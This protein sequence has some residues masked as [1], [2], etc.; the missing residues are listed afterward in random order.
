MEYYIGG[1]VS[2]G[3][4]DFIIL[5]KNKHVVEEGFQLDDT[6][7]NHLKLYNI[8]KELLNKEVE[9]KVYSAFESTG[10]YENNW[11]RYIATQNSERGLK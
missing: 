1:D 9:S 6:Q 7:E 4:C 11:V 2:K 3:Y 10:G 5:D 8:L